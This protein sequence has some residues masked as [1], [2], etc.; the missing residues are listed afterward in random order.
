MARLLFDIETVG[1][2]LDTFDAVQQEYLLR[3]A[4][5]DEARAAIIESFNLTPLTAR[6]CCIAMLN[7]DSAQGRVVYLADAASEDT[8]D[9]I[10][11]VAV[12]EEHELLT[13]FW[14]AI[15][16]ANTNGSLL[17]EKFITFNGRGFDC[18]FVMMR[19]AVLGIKPTRNLMTGGRFSKV[20]TH[21]DLMEELTFNAYGNSGATRRF[22]LDFYCKAFGIPTP[23]AEAVTGHN[24]NA[25]F[26]EGRYRE[27]AEYCVRDVR[28]TAELFAKWHAMLWFPNE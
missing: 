13:R 10:T 28:A 26:A 18:P 5:T 3:K 1:L 24:I 8:L 15:G 17:Y 6:V 7:I 27:I 9:G 21:I 16:A 12:T 14:A 11:F 20:K 23:K 25:V 19:S 22:N 2:P 4:D